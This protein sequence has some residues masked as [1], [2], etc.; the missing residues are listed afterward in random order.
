MTD[1]QLIETAPKDGTPILCYDPKMDDLKVYVVKWSEINIFYTDP[2]RIISSW[3]EASGEEWHG[4]A[5]THWMPLPLP[6][7]GEK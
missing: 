7:R 1:W 3:I 5:P 4:W 2:P 6:P